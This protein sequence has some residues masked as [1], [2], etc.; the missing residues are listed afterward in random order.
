MSEVM[1]MTLYLVIKLTKSL[2]TKYV[3]IGPSLFCLV[4]LI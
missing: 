1:V 4:L 2:E 3:L